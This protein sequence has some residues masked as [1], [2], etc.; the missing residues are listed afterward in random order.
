MTTPARWIGEYEIIRRLR[1]GGMATLFLA[2][3]HGAAGFSRNVVLKV[4]H[5]HLLDQPRFVEM[6]VD[7]ARI[8][9]LISHPNVVHVE[10]FGEA[11]G[12]HYLVMEYIDGCSVS[13]LLQKLKH[14]GR[15]LDPVLAASIILQVARGLHAAHEAKDPDGNPL[16]IIHRDISPSNILLST[17]GHA[18]LIDFGIAK[19]RNRIAETEAGFA[20][21]GKFKYV[22][23][24]QA[25]RTDIDRRSD[26]FSLGV[27]FWELL[28]GAPLFA[29]DTQIGLFNRLT[30]TVVRPPSMANPA[31]LVVL[32]ALVLSMLQHDPADRPATAAEVQRRIASVLPAA[33]ASEGHELGFLVTEVRQRRRARS[34]GAD[35]VTGSSMSFSAAP[36]P[37]RSVRPDNQP[38]D[39]RVEILPPGPEAPTVTE[40]PRPSGRIRWV[41]AAG[42]LAVA[43]AVGV[44]I[45]QRKDSVSVTSPAPAAVAPADAMQARTPP[46]LPPSP[47]VTASAAAKVPSPAVV[48][49]TEELPRNPPNRAK[50]V[51]RARVPR[52]VDKPA[53][54][55]NQP[56]ET[57]QPAK[58]VRARTIRADRASFSDTSFDDAANARSQA[59]APG[60]TSVKKTPI[61]TDF[62]N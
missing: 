22:A 37:S 54:S 45:G 3:R 32:D 14:E 58:A 12:V 2:R 49:T 6:F 18:R 30:S 19:A 11:N 13:E 17:D 27:V 53:P 61:A 40:V 24:E 50:I 15:G 62:G 48:A 21:K 31:A 46:V 8:S 26:V 20:M 7:E 55:S 29:D 35:E 42:L 44:R 47:A 41:A 34:T 5:P 9:S 25:T 57:A 51:P 52:A 16:D 4:V 39:Y 33:A 1:V 56:V 60:R 23:P 10:E 38:E 59:A 43:V 28:V 36:Q